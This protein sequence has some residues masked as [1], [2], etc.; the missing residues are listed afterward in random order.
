LNKAKQLI[1]TFIKPI[2]FLIGLLMFGLGI[3]G[4][5]VP[6]LPTTPF[7]ILAAACF[8]RSSDRFYKLVINNKIFGK[9]VSDY[10]S[11]KGMPFRVKIIAWVMMWCFGLYAV[12]KGIP[13]TLLYIRIL[14]F[15]LLIIGTIFIYR[16]PTKII[17][18]E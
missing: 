11:G 17:D 13:E 14:V 10:R 8:V 18:E 3:I 1:T 9:T 12:F 6:G 16:V 7:M 15:I 5:A 4:I 2:L